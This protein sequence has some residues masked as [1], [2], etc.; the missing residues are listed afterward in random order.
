MTAERRDGLAEEDRPS[1]GPVPTDGSAT[2]AASDAFSTLGGET[3]LAVV[4]ALSRDAPQ[5]FSALFDATDEDTSAGFAYH[6]RQLT[7]R[8]VRQRPD[9]R[10]ELTDAG[11]SAARAVR[12]G[13]FTTSVEHDAIDVADD[14]PLCGQCALVATVADNA[15]RVGCSDC[16]TTL[17]RLSFPPSGYE[18]HDT[19]ELPAALD[20]HHRRRIDT[21]DD[22]V[23]PD[24]ASP[25]SATVEPA[26]DD[27][28][29]TLSSDSSNVHC[30]VQVVFEC[31]TCGSGLLCP[32]TLT[33]L[34]HPSVVAFYH[35]HDRDVHDR[36]VWNVGREWRERVV[37]RDPWCI[38]VSVRLGDEE[39]VLYVA[40][41]GRVVDDR[42]H[43]HDDTDRS[44]G[45]TT[46]ASPGGTGR[47]TASERTRHGERSRDEGDATDGATA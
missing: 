18:S 4:R 23:C 42:R 5:S 33:L 45:R 39:L 35:D 38:V 32:V 10:Y 16:D 17:V 47:E 44:N 6:L 8:F 19:D 13:T 41:D 3:R 20:T 12:A 37:S 30:P 31:E 7:G 21:F 36:P 34:D 26:V 11:R 43:S 25:V 46:T 2:G 22:G 14:C 24:C 27:D 40:G 15:T 1:E 9:E 29:S 28:Q